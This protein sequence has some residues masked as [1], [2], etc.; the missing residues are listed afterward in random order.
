MFEYFFT[1]K[2]KFFVTKQ[3]SFISDPIDT[4]TL[5]T[6]APGIVPDSD[7][8]CLVATVTKIYSCHKELKTVPVAKS[9]RQSFIHVIHS[10]TMP[11]LL[12]CR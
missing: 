11:Y 6:F 8:R 12:Y 2:G 10:Q 5:S 7:N 1:S 3:P 4:L 9:S